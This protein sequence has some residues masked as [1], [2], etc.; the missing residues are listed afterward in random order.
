[1]NSL[2]L[3]R[4]AS[5]HGRKTVRQAAF[6]LVRQGEDKGFK[7]RS[8]RILQNAVCVAKYTWMLIHLKMFG[9]D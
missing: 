1:M 2:F 6:L 3:K 7:N 8:Y 5:L 4:G 9:E